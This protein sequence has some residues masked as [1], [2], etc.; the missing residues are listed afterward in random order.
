MSPE[1]AC[2]R[3][4]IRPKV[5]RGVSGFSVTGCG[6]RIFTKTRDGAEAVRALL[7]TGYAT[8]D[9]MREEPIGRILLAGR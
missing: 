5:Y 9:R 2:P 4:T 1:R 6:T 7:K 8:A 3:V